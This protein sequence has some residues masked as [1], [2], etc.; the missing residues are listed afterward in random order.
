[1]H[2]RQAMTCPLKHSQALAP[3]MLTSAVGLAVQ[4]LVQQL[5]IGPN[6][7]SNTL[8]G[9]CAI[10]IC[11]CGGRGSLLGQPAVPPAAASEPRQSW[12]APP[13]VCL[14]SRAR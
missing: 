4:L 12:Q 11:C 14:S 7:W 2:G 5:L 3:D 6:R 10:S 9:L 1:M 8:R 13:A